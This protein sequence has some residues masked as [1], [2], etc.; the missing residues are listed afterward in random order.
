[1]F[2]SLWIHASFSC[3][4]ISKCRDFC[5]VKALCIDFQFMWITTLFDN[6]SIAFLYLAKFNKQSLK[7]AV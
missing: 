7:M 5:A 6:G 1:M 3:G 2:E 4:S